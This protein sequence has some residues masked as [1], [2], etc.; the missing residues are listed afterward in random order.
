MYSLNNGDSQVLQRI[1][2]FSRHIL[3]SM[4]ARYCIASLDLLLKTRIGLFKTLLD[5]DFERIEEA[6]GFHVHPGISRLETCFRAS[7]SDP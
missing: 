7:T 5:R 6:H 2:S 4:E 3:L 1:V